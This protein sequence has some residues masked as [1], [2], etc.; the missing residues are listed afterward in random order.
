MLPGRPPIPAAV[1]FAALGISL[2]LL[3]AG[4]AWLSV[5]RGALAPAVVVAGFSQLLAFFVSPVDPAINQT[6]FHVPLPGSVAVILL[7]FG[8]LALDRSNRFAE[9]VSVVVPDF[10]P[11]GNGCARPADPSGHIRY[12]HNRMRRGNR[13]LQS[14]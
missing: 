6:L 3:A 5:L 8:I 14:A 12:I 2:A 10:G 9:F 4:Q 7:A 1:A 11:R 13:A